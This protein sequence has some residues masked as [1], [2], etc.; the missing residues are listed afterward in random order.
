M[1]NPNK[2]KINLAGLFKQ[3]QD[4]KDQTERKNSFWKNL[5]G[6]IAREKL[7]IVKHLFYGRNS[8]SKY[9]EILEE[10]ISKKEKGS[11]LKATE[12]STGPNATTTEGSIAKFDIANFF[13][14][15][16]NSDNNPFAIFSKKTNQSNM[17]NDYLDTSVLI[18]SVV[19]YDPV[20]IG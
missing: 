17:S 8:S 3:N 19:A 18:D 13:Y 2:K 7:D 10:K 14:N 15:K 1:A 12:N 4:L 11:I 16:Q 9:Q 5:L 20:D 6:T